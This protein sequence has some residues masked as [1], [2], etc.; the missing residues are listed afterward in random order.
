MRSIERTCRHGG[1]WD[2]I[3]WSQVERD[4][5]RLQGRIYRA[6][7][8]GDYKGVDNLMKLLVRSETAK[9]FAIY[10]ITQKNKG[11][12]T[13]GVDGKVYLTTKERMRLSKDEFDYKSY[14][15]QPILRKYIPK[16]QGNW[17][18]R[19]Y[20]SKKREYG[21][22]E[23]RPLGMMTIKDRVMATIISLALSA[24]WEALLEPNVMGFRPGRCTQDAIQRIYL[25]LMRG[26][27]IILE[28]DINKFFDNIKH[29][30]ILS[31]VKV[32]RKALFRC[33]KVGVVEKGKRIK[34]EKG[35][36]QGSP[37][38]PILANI[39]LSGMQKALGR[40]I[41]VISYADDLIVIAPTIPTMRRVI[42]NL[43]RFLRERGLSLKREKTRITTKRRGFNFL[44]FRVE[45]PRMKLYVKP[46]KE[47]VKKF[48]DYFRELVWSNK[49]IEQRK[50]IAKLNPVIRG[51]AMYYRYSDA[52]EAFS[53]VDHEIFGIVW[54]WARRK[55]NKKGKQWIFKK[56]FEE[57]GKDKWIFKDARTEYALVKASKVQRL[58]YDFIVNDLSPFNPD[59][60]VKEIWNRKRYQEVRH[61]MI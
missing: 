46:Q 26:D 31:K 41:C 13:P 11:K 37:L 28:A 50:L 18:T 15:F 1:W 25:E 3:N 44:G 21:E 48:L 7:K 56:Y 36:V 8:K 19:I 12:S 52:N 39:A 32:F 23:M 16:S 9:L 57:V 61:A 30:A 49:Q 55:H 22:A 60:V 59:P 17:R 53:L 45:Q 10:V 29:D 20:K 4:V 5:R 35:I 43:A 27:K 33:L 24:K 2:E 51:W 42:P 58:K 54:R 34:T 47:K 6:S 38:S 14:K 40:D